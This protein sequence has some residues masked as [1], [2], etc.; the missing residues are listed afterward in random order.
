MLEGTMPRYSFTSSARLW[1][2]A[3]SCIF[4]LCLSSSGAQDLRY[5]SHQSWSTEEGLPQSSVH[6]IVQTRDGYLWIATEGG[7]ARFDGAGFRVFDHSSE[8]A[9]ASDDVCCLAADS[10]GSLWIG[11]ADGLI[12]MQGGQFRRYG[13]ADGLPSSTIESITVRGDGSLVV[14]TSNGWAEWKQTGFQRMSPALLGESTDGS[15]SMAGPGAA[16]WNSTSTTVT[17][18]WHGVKHEWRVGHELPSGRIET[19]TVDREGLAWVGMNSGLLLL[20]MDQPAAIPITFLRGNSVLSIFEDTE[21]NHWIGTETSG[22]HVLRRL[23][24]RSEPMLADKA[25]TNVAQTKDGTIWVG[26]REDGLR[27]VRSGGV[28]EPVAEAALTSSVISCVAPGV[29]GG[30]WVGTPDGLNYIDEKNFVQRITSANGLPDDYVRSLVGD[31]DG[32]VWVGMRHGLAHVQRVGVKLKVKTITSADGLGGDLIGSLLQT[33]GRGPNAVSELWAGT[34]GGLSRVRGNGQITNFTVKNGLGGEIATAMAQDSAG[35]LWVATKDGGLS[36]FDGQRFLPVALFP[37]SGGRDGNIEGIVADKLGFMWFRMDRGI[38]RIALTALHACVADNRCSLPDGAMSKYGLADGLPNDEV[39]SGGLSMAWLANNGELWF[40]TRGGVAVADTEHLPWNTIEPPVVLQRFLVDDS[41]QDFSTMPADISFGHARFTMEY[42]G[43][44]YTAPTEVRYRF[45]L[46]GFDKDWTDAGSR[47][48]ATYTNLPPGS[49]RFRVQAMNNDGVWNRAGTELRFRIIPPFYRQWWFMVVVVLG[50]IAI[51]VGMYLL[52]L[53]RLRREFEAVLAERNRMAR[54]I[55]D[56]LTQDFV[57]TS[58]QLDLI[59]QQLSRGKIEMAIDQVKRARRLVTEG[60]E[61][62]RRS[63]WELRANN[64]QDSLPTRLTRLV[65][66]DS[67]GMIVPRLHLG[68]AY[69]PLDPHV[70]RELLRIVQEALSNVQH[71]ADATEVSVELHYSSDTLMLVIEDNGVGFSTDEASCKVG[72]YG[73]LGMKERTSV[74]DG[75]LE[76]SSQPGHGTRVTLR[77]PIAANAR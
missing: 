42:A 3:A 72:H 55:H 57:G 21:G 4:L 64:S 30:L 34:S 22:L 71:H 46:E 19:V 1:K 53:R 20:S 52:R 40:S 14:N 25:V 70:E 38:R 31:S 62:A 39:V 36:L 23:K 24:F 28:D 58:L 67:P 6:G 11:T 59:A 61:E 35:D 10:A 5:L 49:Y 7:V 37:R 43:L 29:R 41:P 8:P 33:V 45:R 2:L 65:Q 16:L 51:L 63:I 68:G 50:L 47:R 56:T 12:Q 27:R 69:R 26:T 66:R 44:S 18:T 77:I 73:L 48:S 13:T 9:F 74:I 17:L 76:I 15:G 60:L 32:S 75:T 54:E